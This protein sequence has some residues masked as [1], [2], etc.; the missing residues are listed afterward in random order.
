M[1]E[2]TRGPGRPPGSKNKVGASEKQFIQQLLDDTQ[3]QYRKAFINLANSEKPKDQS[4]FMSIRQE[5]AKMVVPRPTELD[6]TSDGKE[7]D[8]ISV[9]FSTWDD[10]EEE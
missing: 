8:Q 4:R 5:L 7:L 10:P 6:I 2:T 1:E 3:Q 9:M